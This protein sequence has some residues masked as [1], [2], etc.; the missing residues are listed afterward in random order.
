MN[1]KQI[2]FC[3]L[4]KIDLHNVFIYAKMRKNGTKIANFYTVSKFASIYIHTR[5]YFIYNFSRNVGTY[6]SNNP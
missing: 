3:Q 6:G 1:G 5:S 2:N 4:T